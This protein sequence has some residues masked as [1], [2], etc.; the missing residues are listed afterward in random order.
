MAKAEYERETYN[1]DVIICSDG[2]GSLN[3]ELIESGICYSYIPID[4]L[5]KMKEGHFEDK[6]YYV[7]EALMPFYN[8]SIF[9]EQPI[10]NIWELTEKKYKNKIIMA[11]PLSSFSTYAYSAVLL[12]ESDRIAQAYTDYTG[13]VL[14]LPEGKTAGEFF[15]EKLS[16]QVVFVN[17]SDDV[18]EGIGSGRE[19]GMMIGIMISSKMRLLEVGYHFAPIYQLNP[20]AAV[21]TPNS[22]LIA[23]GSRNINAAK[24][25][26][27]HLLG[28]TDGKGEG[29][30]PYSTLGTWSVR[31]DIED[32]NDV[33]LEEI[34]VIFF[35][36]EY[37]YEKNEYIRT[38][39]EGILDESVKE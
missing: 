8:T 10:H 17:S 7:G 25:F 38:F 19:Q 5:P 27:W 12:K 11:N 32:G 37:L 22:A 31:K 23:G 35:D 14:V 13:E 28:E 1:C 33:G 2:D 3:Q 18:I 34:D 21:Y 15:W 26:I 30:K 36:R 9:E 16:E 4:I 6:L 39:L 24:L 29:I 20:Y